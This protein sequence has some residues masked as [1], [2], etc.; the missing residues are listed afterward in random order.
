MGWAGSIPNIQYCTA[1]CLALSGASRML[2]QI[3]NLVRVVQIQPKFSAGTRTV[4]RPCTQV[5]TAVLG[6]T[7]AEPPGVPRYPVLYTGIF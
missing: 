2:N 1:A 4:G 7:P 3:V 5:Y 6:R